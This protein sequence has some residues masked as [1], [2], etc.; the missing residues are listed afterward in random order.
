MAAILVVK[1]F[2][3]SFEFI[4]NC[5]GFHKLMLKTHQSD[6]WASD[7][8]GNAI[9]NENPPYLSIGCMDGILIKLIVSE[10]G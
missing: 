5:S 3:I 10:V 1:G 6:K 8:V 2:E 7:Q 4:L 9:D